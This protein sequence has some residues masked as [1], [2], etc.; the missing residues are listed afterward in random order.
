[1]DSNFQVRQWIGSGG[2]SDHS[3]IWLVLDGG[4]IK[5]PSPFKFNASWLSDESFLDLVKSNWRPFDPSSGSPVGLHFA[6]N[7]KRIKQLAIPWAREKRIKEERELKHT[8][9]QIE[10]LYQSTTQGF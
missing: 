7:L 4:S 2:E 9:D 3:P 8:E 5:P 10:I 6:D 1:M